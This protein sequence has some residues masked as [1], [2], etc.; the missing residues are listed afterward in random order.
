MQLTITMKGNPICLPIAS[1]HTVQ[2]FLYHALRRDGAYSYE[3]HETG[4]LY[5]K[6]KFKLFTF[7]ELMGQYEIRGKNI[8]YPEDVAL[9][10]RSADT[11]MIQLLF[12]A[13]S[14]QPY[15]MLGNNPIEITGVSLLNE[16]VFSDTIRIR[17]LSPITVYRTE[18]NGHTTYFSPTEEEFYTSVIANAK[19]KWSSFSQDTHCDFSIEPTETA[20]FTKRATRFKE[21]FIT[22]WHGEFI[23]RG[24]PRM[25]NFLYHTGLGTKNSQGFGMFRVL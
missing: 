19:R 18:E 25:L 17:T 4:T 13:F 1:A 11:Y 22:A 16:T 3:L 10:I 15:A 5:D 9:E 23:L 7:G 21:T 24:S 20:R 8:I 2:G 14:R 12:E 6:K